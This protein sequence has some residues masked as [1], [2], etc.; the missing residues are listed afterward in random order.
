LIEALK[1]VER[2]LGTDKVRYFVIVWELL[3]MVHLNC[4]LDR[5]RNFFPFSRLHPITLVGNIFKKFGIAVVA[6]LLL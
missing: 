3:I 5:P 6:I 4:S 1:S 2:P